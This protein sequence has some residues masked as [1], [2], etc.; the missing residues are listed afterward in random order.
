MLDVV[1][2]YNVDGINLD[3]IRAMGVCT[4]NSCQRSYRTRTGM[5]LLTDY[6]NTALDQNARDRIQSWQD[7]AV[8]SIVQDFSV[9]ARMR[10]PKLVISVDSHAV[11][12][13]TRRALEGR[14]EIDWARSRRRSADRA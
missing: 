2:R 9:R 14:D 13:E 5:E 1:T 11:G 8:G 12:A 7:E 3:Y 4:S 6:A 10:K